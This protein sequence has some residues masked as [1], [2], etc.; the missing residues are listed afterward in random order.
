[1]KKTIYDQ[2]KNDNINQEEIQK[3]QSLNAILKSIGFALVF[4][5]FCLIHVA[6]QFTFHLRFY[7][8][9]AAVGY[10]LALLS[11][12]KI[13]PY[14]IACIPLVAYYVIAGGIKL[15]EPGIIE[16][17][18]L[19]GRLVLAMYYGIGIFANVQ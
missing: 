10:F 3:K 6:P 16:K 7:D 11:S 5:F 15:V 1:M 12:V 17:I 9:F 2:K 19:I 4:S 13:V 8:M 18:Q 14:W